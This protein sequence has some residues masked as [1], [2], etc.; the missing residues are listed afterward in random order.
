MDEVVEYP[1]LGAHLHLHFPRLVQDPFFALIEDIF[2]GNVR[3]GILQEGVR[4]ATR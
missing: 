2:P 4:G 3:L 1:N